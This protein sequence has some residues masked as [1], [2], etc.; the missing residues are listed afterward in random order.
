MPNKKK[1]SKDMT[2]KE[3]R[4]AASKR[5]APVS[6]MPMRQDVKYK[7]NLMDVGRLAV[8]SG[9]LN[10]PA[11]NFKKELDKAKSDAYGVP[12]KKLS[13]EINPA[14]RDVSMKST[15]KVNKKG[16]PIKRK[17]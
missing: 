3:L 16:S 12:S 1:A 14:K 15:M 7:E 11:S 9:G 8:R 17:K 5:A 13:M 4:E 10:Q 6:K 2:Q